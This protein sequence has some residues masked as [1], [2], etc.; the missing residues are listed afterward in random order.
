MIKCEAFL[1][2][3]C[4]VLGIEHLQELID[5]LIDDWHRL[6]V[7]KGPLVIPQVVRGEFKGSVDS[8]GWPIGFLYTED[9]R[10]IVAGVEFTLEITESVG[11]IA[12]A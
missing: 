10:V 7:G 8:N 1:Y 11:Q 2:E 4:V 5:S 6:G 12:T 9:G 3:D